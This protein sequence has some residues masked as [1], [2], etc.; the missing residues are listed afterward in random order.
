MEPGKFLSRVCGMLCQP[1][2][3]ELFGSIGSCLGQIWQSVSKEFKWTKCFDKVKGS[4]QS[5]KAY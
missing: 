2:E 3:L 4:V 1:V 5:V